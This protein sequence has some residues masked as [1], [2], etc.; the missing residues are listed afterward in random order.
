[1]E[2]TSDRI[3][4]ARRLIERGQYVE[5][6]NELRMAVGEGKTYA[7]V[8]NLIGM[9]HSLRGEYESAATYYRKALDLNP[10]YEEARLNLMIT[11]SDLGRYDNVETEM[12]RLY[13]SV[14]E[15]GGHN[16][17]PALASRL[18]NAYLDLSQLEF[19]AGRLKESERLIDAALELAPQYPDIHVFRGK[20]LRR[21]GRIDEAGETLQKA[22]EINP[23]YGKGH[24]ELGI[25]YFGAGDLENAKEHLRSAKLLDESTGRTV[26]LY[27]AYIERKSKEEVGDQNEA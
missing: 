7:D 21:F 2:E 9:C 13:G 6:L 16:L 11:L 3:G 25:V 15:E 1:M 23:K 4:A 26:D 18:A 12:H 27:L 8:F 10:D 19:Q 20:L 5:A 24:L 14:G 22:L 17:Q